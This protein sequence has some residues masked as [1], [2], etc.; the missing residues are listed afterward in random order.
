LPPLALILAG[1]VAKL[2]SVG[3]R[4][5]A[6]LAVT[7]AGLHSHA[8]LTYDIGLARL[9]YH[10]STGLVAARPAAEPR[11]RGV[12]DVENPW[13]VGGVLDLATAEADRERGALGRLVASSP[14]SLLRAGD[15]PKVQTVRQAYL[16]LL[17][18]P[19]EPAGL[20]A[21][22]HELERGS[23]TP[24]GLVRAIASSD[25][26][27]GRPARVLVVTN[28]PF[29]N[30]SVLRYYAERARLRLTFEHPERSLPAL[31]VADL[32][33]LALLKS[34]GDQGPAHTTL[35]VR[36]LEQQIRREGSSWRPLPNRF[37]CP[38]GA[39]VEVFGSGAT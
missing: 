23:L 14:A 38:D 2:P 26:F 15:Q 34:G 27:R 22:V 31:A 30:A 1:A 4:R 37:S 8:A 7:L 35:L 28:H 6:A 12:G 36:P 19:P 20:A 10:L 16:R 25:E 39:V 33:D 13:P 24:E 5:L 21:Y 32:Y 17:K 9:Y 3:G 18:R 11:A 29:L